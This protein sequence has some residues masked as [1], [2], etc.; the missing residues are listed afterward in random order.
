M[1]DLSRGRI[2]P[3]LRGRLGRPYVH[4][5]VCGTT[6]LLLPPD[7]P[8]GAVATADHQVAGRGRRGRAWVDE[9]GAALLAS[10]LFRPPEGAVAAQL[11][12]VCAL[13]VAEAVEKAIGR[14]AGVKWPNDVVVEG[15]KVAGILLEARNGTVVCGVGI[16]VGQDAASLPADARTPPASLRTLTG[17]GHDR[18]LLLVDLLE[19]LERRYDVW[20]G[21]GLGLLLPELERRDALRGRTVS[22]DTVAGSA[23]GIAADGALRVLAA[24][25]TERLVASGEVE[26]VSD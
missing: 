22:V 15:R 4:E 23:G 18:A 5:D 9:P 20:C 10:I 2:E 19:R 14:S 12:L 21:S 1:S 24:D 3:L 25:G 7:A 17:R 26:M 6:Q 16:N 13:A 8:E 11:S